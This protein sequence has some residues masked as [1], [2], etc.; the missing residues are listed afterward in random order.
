MR[1]FQQ[2]ALTILGLAMLAIVGTAYANWYST[3]SD[4]FDAVLDCEEGIRA[5]YREVGIPTPYDPKELW[6]TCA[7]KVRE[8]YKEAE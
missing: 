8:Q 7:T 2:V 3:R 6:E 5:E 4:F 1:I